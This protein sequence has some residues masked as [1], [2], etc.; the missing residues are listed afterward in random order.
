MHHSSPAV[1]VNML[2]A[3]PIRRSSSRHPSRQHRER[4]YRQKKRLR[5][6]SLQPH[7]HPKPCHLL[8]PSLHSPSD[9]AGRGRLWNRFP[10]ETFL[11]V[12]AQVNM[13]TSSAPPALLP[14]QYGG[15]LQK[16]RLRK[17]HW[18]KHRLRKLHW[19]KHRLQKLHQQ[20][21][22]LRNQHCPPHRQN[23]REQS[24]HRNR[25]GHK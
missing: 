17:L 15:Y 19:Q 25:I 3:P 24:H 1:Q 18:Q 8:L 20:K 10:R 11:Q 5:H 14:H 23:R 9:S 22:R 7:Q 16:H 4:Q 21:H 13:P 12:P 6:Q 2:T